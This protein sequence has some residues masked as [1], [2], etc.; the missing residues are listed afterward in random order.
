[1][2][3]LREIEK[4]VSN[5]PANDLAEFR[6]WFQKFDASLWDKQFEDDARKGKLDRLAQKAV[7][8]FKNGKCKEL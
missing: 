8:D 3:R 4:A 1:M 6:A 7:Q 2:V 5:L